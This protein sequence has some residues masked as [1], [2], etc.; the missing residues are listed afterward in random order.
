MWG[1]VLAL[2]LFATADPVRIGIALFLSSRPRPAHHLLALVLGGLALSLVAGAIVLFALH[3]VAL[4]LMHGV[5]RTAASS[6]VGHVQIVM[7]VLALAIAGPI[8]LG[9][10]N[11]HRARLAMSGTDPLALPPTGPTAAERLFARADQALR[12]RS[13]WVAFL[14]GAG[15]TTDLRYLA[16]LTAIL[17]SGAATGAQI[18]AAAMY[19]LVTLAFAE[20][21]LASLLAAPAR[22]HSV[23]LQLHT[24]IYARRRAI[25]AVVV[26]GVGVVLTTTGVGHL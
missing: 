17:A 11:R 2:A 26:A 24:W 13:L 19:T 16:A 18:S 12:G 1:T 22:T 20:I 5:T 21:P 10:P 14:L 3:D 25:V 9:F 4:D 8:A 15:L 6:T 7:G 23:M